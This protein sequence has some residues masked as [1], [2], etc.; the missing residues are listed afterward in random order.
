MAID[1]HSDSAIFRRG[2]WQDNPVLIQM[3]GL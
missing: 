1:K 3:L 2:I